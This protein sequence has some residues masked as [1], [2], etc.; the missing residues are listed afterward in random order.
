MERQ[1]MECHDLNTPSRIPVA[2]VLFDELEQKFVGRRASEWLGRVSAATV[3][4]F[5]TAP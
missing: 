4:R 5:R 1:A 3:G 2:Y